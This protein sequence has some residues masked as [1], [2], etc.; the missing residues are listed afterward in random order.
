MINSLI[1]VV[2]VRV[3][4]CMCVC[5]VYVCGMYVVY[6]CVCG[7]CMRMWGPQVNTQVPLSLALHLNY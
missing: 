3:C 1:L 4:V 2:C 6:I 7:V 5:V